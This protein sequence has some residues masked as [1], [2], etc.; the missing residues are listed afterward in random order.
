M[1]HVG[2]G[3]CPGRRVAGRVHPLQ[4][5]PAAEHQP[6]GDAHGDEEQERHQRPDLG[7]RVDH[8]VGAE[9]AGDGPGCSDERLDRGL[10]GQREPVRGD[11]AGDQVEQQVRELAEL[12]L[13]VVAEDDEEQHVAE[14]VQPAL[15][16][17]HGEQHRQRRR[18]VIG[19]PAL[20]AGVRAGPGLAGRDQ[21]KLVIGDQLVRDRRVV[22]V[23]RLLAAQLR[24]GRR[25]GQGRLRPGGEQQHD[26][27]GRDQ[28][29]GDPRR[30]ADRI[31]VVNRQHHASRFA[32]PRPRRLRQRRDEP[33]AVR[34]ARDLGLVPDHFS[35]LDTPHESTPLSRGKRQYRA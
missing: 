20:V 27:V 28:A 6:R 12:V 35:A 30:P 34:P 15:V 14:Q 31:D 13:D 29:V 23:E 8:Q 11:V 32:Q 1:G 10:V 17:E 19:R 7:P 18:L 21:G 9:H 22:V 25:A 3:A 33:A 26:D 16:D 4:D 5:E 24:R 2:H